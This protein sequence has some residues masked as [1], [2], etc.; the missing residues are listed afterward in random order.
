MLKLRFDWY[1][2]RGGKNSVSNLGFIVLNMSSLPT[3]S[4]Q[5]SNKNLQVVHCCLNKMFEENSLQQQPKPSDSIYLNK[6]IF[7][8]FHVS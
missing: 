4:V 7:L 8:W 6:I 2:N 5:L 1:I 3:R